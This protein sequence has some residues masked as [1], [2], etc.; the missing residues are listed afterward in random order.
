MSHPAVDIIYIPPDLNHVCEKLFSN[1]FQHFLTDLCRT[2]DQTIEQ[3]F[4]ARAQTR[5]KIY[6]REVN[7]PEESIQS[8]AEFIKLEIIDG[9]VK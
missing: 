1:E 4:A 6:L 2:F 8:L 7:Q 9:I 3:L 5:S